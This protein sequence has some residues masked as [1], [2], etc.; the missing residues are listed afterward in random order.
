MKPFLHRITTVTC[1][2][3]YYVTHKTKTNFEKIKYNCK[4]FKQVMDLKKKML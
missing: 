2:L 4:V 1:F 3:H